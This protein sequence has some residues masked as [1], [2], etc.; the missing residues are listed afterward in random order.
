MLFC[1]Q[2]CSSRA[3]TSR[4]RYGGGGDAYG[5]PHGLTTSYLSIFVYA[6]FILFLWS[7]FIFIFL[8]FYYVE[9][10]Q[11]YKLG[12]LCIYIIVYVALVYNV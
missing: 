8:Y 9:Y 3:R 6:Y 1:K 10:L 5:F 4:L 11:F 12:V 2:V 7:L